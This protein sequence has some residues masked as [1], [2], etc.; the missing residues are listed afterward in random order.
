MAVDA[1]ANV[2]A[3][4]TVLRS[5]PLENLHGTYVELRHE[6]TGARHLHVACDDDN[7]SF[8]VMFPTL[9]T[10]S[11]GVAHILEHVVL[12]GSERYPVRDPFF[13]MLPRSLS[14][15]MN[16]LTYADRTIYPFSS[17]NQKDFLNLLD[18]Y[19]DSTFF[20]RLELDSFRQEGH[21]LD[22][23]SPDDPESELV[24]KGVVFNEMKGT[25]S[26]QAQVMGRGVG[27]ALFPDLTYANNSGGDPERI[28]DLTW[29]ELK[30][31]HRRNYHPSNAVFLTY[32]S[33][34]LASL[35]PIIEARVL[36]RFER[37]EVDNQIGTQTAF[38]EPRRLDLEW[39]GAAGTAG[40]PVGQAL[41]AWAT[42]DMADDYESLCMQALG[43]LLLGNSASPLQNALITSGI[44]KALAHG[45]GFDGSFRQGV[46]AAGLRDIEPSRAD[47]VQE[48]V[49]QT[50]ARV[51]DE[52]IDPALVAATCHQIE[53]GIRERSNA[54]FP[55]SLKTLLGAIAPAYQ[56]GGD[57]VRSISP[58]ADLERLGRE[59]SVP[60]FFEDLVRRRLIQNR[61]RSLVTLRANPSGEA[62]RAAAEAA[63]LAAV[64]AALPPGGVEQVRLDAARLAASQE[65]IQDT[66]SLPRL[67]LSDIPPNVEPPPYEEIEMSGVPVSF[68][69]Q[70]TNGITYLDLRFDYSALT[71][72]AQ[73]HLPL[74]GE[75]ISEMG[76]AGLSYA[77]M[78][79]RVALRTGGISAHPGVAPRA[80][81]T[82]DRDFSISTLAL[83]RNQAEM[84]N[85]LRDL[86]L[87][88]EFDP[89]RLRE[90]VAEAR[91]NAQNAVISSGHA[92]AAMAATSTLTAQGALNERL[93][94]LTQLAS[95]KAL[96]D[97]GDAGLEAERAALESL[98]GELVSRAGLQV[99]VTADPGARDSILAL[100]GGLIE[101]LPPG[102]PRA[103][104]QPALT[105][106]ASRRA[107]SISGA[108]AYNA[109]VFPTVRYL[110][111]DAPALAVLGHFLRATFLHREVREKGGAYGVAA[112]ASANSGV[113]TMTSYR[114]PN[115]LATYASFEAARRAAT[116]GPI[117]DA[118]REEAI[119]GAS[120][121]MDPLE[122]PDTRG[123]RA[124]MQR[125]G[126]Y[127][128]EVRRTYKER[129]LAVTEADL[130][131]V[132][133]RYLDPAAA[134]RVTVGAELLVQ[135]ATASDPG[136]FLSVT[137]V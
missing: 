19:L 92:F 20:P 35:L 93:G 102:Q 123:R 94:G 2:H 134:A 17:R 124:W 24:I 131:R 105:P 31:F 42:C 64:R 106:A 51:A 71:E 137:A 44:G 22:L 13:S 58:D 11:S 63:R 111:P 97:G 55:Y 103:R 108:V 27:L 14:T 107:F 70:P 59:S 16:A 109:M 43:E 45:T 8:A 39:P 115:V 29:E 119:L 87:S 57:P 89:S 66:S 95:L 5:E 30:A 129:L 68:Y 18:V 86:S 126:G 23:A 48:L 112:Q 25:M 10:T 61:H 122:S 85:I 127:T 83:E 80:E 110:D 49:L 46:F 117:D 65:A 32:G 53:L 78:A 91:T 121:E 132:A 73:A 9:P 75:C 133:A 98:L 54:G 88:L 120:K 56:Y 99:C 128:P 118:D 6:R 79:A 67:A 100:V 60:G 26:A 47:E 37:L 130:R 82:F 34:P 84:V 76:A 116:E 114:D 74:L 12:C 101:S 3:G 96:D 7:N 50:L 72:A 77:E 1:T 135:A 36:S 40:A 113:M 62:D 28:P 21:H 38:Q 104:T 69:P 81:G 90:L 136:A 4:F 52:G 41:V 33:T 15:F 125:L